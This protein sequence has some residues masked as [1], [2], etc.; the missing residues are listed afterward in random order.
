MYKCTRT[1]MCKYIITSSFSQS[2]IRG[3]RKERKHSSNDDENETCKVEKGNII[4]IIEYKTSEKKSLSKENELEEETGRA[5][6]LMCPVRSVL[7]LSY[8]FMKHFAAFSW[9]AIGLQEKKPM[10]CN[11]LQKAYADRQK[12][13]VIVEQGCMYL[14][15]TMRMIKKEKQKRENGGEIEYGH[16]CLHW[17]RWCKGFLCTQL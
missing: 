2:F 9:A 11:K 4:I 7:F 14:E 10:Q 3:W 5:R 16:V 6:I 1:Y 8:V 17:W 13:P 12:E 15:K